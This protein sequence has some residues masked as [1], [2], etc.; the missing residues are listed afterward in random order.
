MNFTNLRNL[1]EIN[2]VCDKENNKII[3]YI[4]N[5]LSNKGFINEFVISK[6]NKKCLISKS[7]DECN[8]CFFGHSDTVSFDNNWTKEPLSLTIDFDNLYGR[9]VCDMKGGIA[10]FLDAINNTNIFNLKKGIMV[11]I[12]YDEEIGFNGINL[13][14]NNDKIKDIPNNIIICEPTDSVPIIACKGCIEYRVEFKGISTHSSNI[15][16]GVNAINVA[17]TF[18]N[19]FYNE[20]KK[21]INN[22]YDISYTTMNISTINGGTSINIVPD[23]CSI[24]FDFRT[25]LNSHNSLINNKI[26]ELCNKYNC[27][28]NKITDVLPSINNSEDIKFIEKITNKKSIGYNYVT[29]GNFI[30]KSNMVILGPGPVTAHEV[31]EYISI[32]S[33][34]NIVDIYEKIIDKYCKGV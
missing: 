33:Y 19:E 20:I 13:L 21:D 9:G 8:L 4:A 22:I 5:V 16:N 23:Y 10:A 14:I 26:I 34:K 6:D 32:N 18:I 29:E 12:T 30:N 3:D 1:I 28:Y 17:N 2:T 7:S 24:T 11:V 25:I 31:D 27:K 15:P